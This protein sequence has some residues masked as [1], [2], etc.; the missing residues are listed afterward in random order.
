MTPL[1]G[2]AEAIAAFGAAAAGPRLHHAW[3]LAGPKG[4]GKRTF[5]EQAAIWLLSG[6]TGAPLSVDPDHPMTKLMIA[7][8]HPDFKRIERLPRDLK[9]RELPRLE[10]S[11]DEELSRNISIDQIRALQPLFAT[12]VAMADGR[13]VLI[14]SIDD[15]EPSAANALLKNLEEPPAGTIFLL[16]SHAPGRLLP[17][18]RSRCRVLRLQPLDDALT[19]AVIASKQPNAGEGD[20]DLLVDMSEG[21]PGVGLRLGRLDVAALDALLADIELTGD[22]A[23]VARLSLGKAVSGK[24]MQARFEMFLERAPA[25]IAGVARRRQGAALAEAISAWEAARS[26]VSNAIPRTLDPAQV[27]FEMGTLVAGLAPKATAT[28]A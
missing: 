9:Q 12:T 4:I 21:A 28:K 5:A 7:D 3:L 2:H 24:A 26:L 18:I 11:R 25:F 27:A 23:N 15:L 14:D 8:T 13:V 20:I 16:V 22:P 6:R 17:T 19:G 1:I 10:R